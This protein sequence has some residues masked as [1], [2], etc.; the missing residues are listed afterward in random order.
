MS[1]KLVMLMVRVPTQEVA[2][3]FTV[4][5]ESLFVGLIEVG[6]SNRTGSILILFLFIL[7]SRNRSLSYALRLPR[8]EFPAQVLVMIHQ[9]VVLEILVCCNK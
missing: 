2:R 8:S 6:S 3:R 1:G 9:R 7:F 5:Y 4:A